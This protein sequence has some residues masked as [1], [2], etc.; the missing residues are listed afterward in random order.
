MDR[1][2]AVANLAGPQHGAV[3]TEQLDAAG[4]SARQRGG[5]VAR[6]LLERFGPHS[7]VVAASPSTW[8]RAVWAAGADLGGHGFVAGRAAARLHRL[9]GFTSDAIELLVPRTHRRVRSP[10]VVRSTSGPLS[11]ADTVSIDGIRCVTVER[12]VLTAPLF[13]FSRAELENAIDS[14]IRMR[15]V[16]E[17]RLRERVVAEH[18]RSTNGGR[19]LLEALVDTGG[20]SRL[21]RWFRAIVREAGLARPAMRV[22]HRIGTRTVARIDAAFPGGL[23]V[24]LEGHET[25]SSRRS[26]QHDEQRRTELTLR[27]HRVIVFTYLDVGDRPGW[28]AAQVRSALRQVP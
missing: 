7:Y 25:H 22:V 26:R 1:Y 5:W 13:A 20:E 6:G 12:L 24:E 4:V 23:I 27:G 16:S 21:E 15:L 10:H 19:A 28:V 18:D 11:Q 14:G 8:R 3:S 2:V 17:R 9:D